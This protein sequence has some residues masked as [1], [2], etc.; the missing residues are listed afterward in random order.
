M[1]DYQSLQGLSWQEGKT[2]EEPKPTRR[3][4]QTPLQRAL[5]IKSQVKTWF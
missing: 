5:M 3:Y 1:K 4:Q 2:F